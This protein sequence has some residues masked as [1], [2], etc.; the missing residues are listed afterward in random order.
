VFSRAGRLCHFSNCHVTQIIN[1][2]SAAN[3]ISV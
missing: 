2:L 3:S 1:R